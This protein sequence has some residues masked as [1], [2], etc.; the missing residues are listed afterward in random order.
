MWKC[1]KGCGYVACEGCVSKSM[2]LWET[3]SS[4]SQPAAPPELK[5]RV[6]C[7]YGRK[8]YQGG[9]D[10][11]AKFAHPGDRDYCHGFASFMSG[12]RPD[13]ETLWDIFL[14]FDPK[15][16]GHLFREEF[17]RAAQEVAALSPET[18]DVGVAWAEA[19]G[20]DQGHVSFV[21]FAN[22]CAR[23]G[24][25]SPVGLNTVEGAPRTCRF[26]SADGKGCACK[27][28]RAAAGS[29]NMCRC[30]HRCHG[31]RSDSAQQTLQMQLLSSRPAHWV[32][33]GIGLV[34]LTDPAV[35][36][37]M[38]FLLDATHLESNNWTR[39]RGCALHGVN[40]CGNDCIF[41]N[42]A[43]VPTGY[44]LVGAWRNQNPALWARYSLI[45]A[46]ILQ[47][48]RKT[49]CARCNLESSSP[50]FESID[51]SGLV[52]KINEC[53]LFHGTSASACREI[54]EKNFQLSL[55]GTGATW[56]TP[57]KSTGKSLY[58]PGVYLAERITKADEYAQGVPGDAGAPQVFSI[59]LCRALAGRVCVCED[60]EI[61]P[62]ALRQQVLDGPYHCVLGDRVAKLGKPFREVVIYDR[63]QLYPEFLLTYT[64]I[65]PHT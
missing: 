44:R 48:C 30:G 42:R 31:H 58:G 1:Q 34:P 56:K 65:L 35:L 54:C 12:Q 22:W 45:R 15:E 26:V 43:R 23:V 13:V 61:D 19:G 32:S 6:A 51:A 40:R 20:A 8:C 24:L 55:A 49:P 64:R 5:Q 4:P 28:F 2:S 21:R 62:D 60:N 57:G 63:D 16:S 27:D 50:A 39:D 7:R 9:S 59:L 10:H 29:A 53:R 14:F 37:Q 33:S 46:T 11:L 18:V 52:G 17:L 36:S 38:Q 3:G 41:A 47:E 25:R